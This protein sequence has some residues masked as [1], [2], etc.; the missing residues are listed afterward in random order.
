M[1]T[2]Y[3]ENLTNQEASPSWEV[4]NLI[5]HLW[6]QTVSGKELLFQVLF[7]LAFHLNT[8]IG[9]FSPD[10]L[11][12]NGRS[13]WGRMKPLQLI[14]IVLKLEDGRKEEETV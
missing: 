1:N 2:W 4:N 9:L 14:C 6:A 5:T 3:S 7:C 10:H 11:L 8:Q 13:R 12:S